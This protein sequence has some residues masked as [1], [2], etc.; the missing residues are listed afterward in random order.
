MYLSVCSSL[1]HA[2]IFIQTSCPGWRARVP[3]HLSCGRLSFPLFLRA[4][5]AFWLRPYVRVLCPTLP[6]PRGAGS[7]G[8]PLSLSVA[9]G[10]VGAGPLYALWSAR[11]CHHLLVTHGRT[12]TRKKSYPSWLLTTAGLWQLKKTNETGKGFGHA[13]IHSSL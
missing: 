7:G 8:A 10:A 5:G 11:V 2:H 12:A 1:L 13:E 9:T 4:A 3:P 6:P